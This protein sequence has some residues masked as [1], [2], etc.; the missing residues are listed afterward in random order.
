[1]SD[2]TDPIK[3]VRTQGARTSFFP[4]YAL[5]VGLV[6][7]SILD[8]FLIH[9]PIFEGNIIFLIIGLTIAVS[10]FFIALYNLNIF[11]DN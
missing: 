9:L 11:S 8:S 2:N 4:P 6:A 3:P 7:S 5:M 10:S 1:M